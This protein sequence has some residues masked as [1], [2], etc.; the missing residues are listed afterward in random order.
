MSA[1]QTFFVFKNLMTECTSQS[2]GLVTHWRHSEGPA[3][4]MPHLETSPVGGLRSYDVQA[5]L[6]Y[7]WLSYKLQC[8]ITEPRDLYNTW[9][10]RVIGR[11]AEINVKWNGQGITKLKGA[12]QVKKNKAPGRLS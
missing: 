7:K 1:G 10:P 2:V 4:T 12:K 8:V 3:Q 9:L 6:T 11:N 5:F